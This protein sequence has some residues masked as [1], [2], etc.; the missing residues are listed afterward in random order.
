M[1]LKTPEFERFWKFRPDSGKQEE[2]DDGPGEQEYPVVLATERGNHAMGIFSPQQP[3]PGYEKA[4]YGRFRFKD[5]KVVKWNCV[6][7]VRDP[8]RVAPGEYHFRMFVPVGE[9]KT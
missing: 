2:L 5:Q 9:S 4:G 7:R 3:S 6:F 1:M 8:Q